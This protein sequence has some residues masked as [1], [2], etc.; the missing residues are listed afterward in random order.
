VH[1]WNGSGRAQPKSCWRRLFTIGKLSKQADIQELR[2]M[3]T[4][5]SPML[6][7]RDGR[8]AIAFYQQVSGATLL[9]EVPHRLSGRAWHRSDAGRAAQVKEIRR[10]VACHNAMHRDTVMSRLH[11]FG[12]TLVNSPTIGPKTVRNE[13]HLDSRDPYISSALVSQSAPVRQAP[14]TRQRLTSTA[15][16]VIAQRKPYSPTLRLGLSR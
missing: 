1:L 11:V 16:I 9:W 6:A 13:R 10:R 5:I 7:V 3:T 4:Q 8:A 2:K 12:I 14:S 15:S